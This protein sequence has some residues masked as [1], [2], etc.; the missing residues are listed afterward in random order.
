MGALGLALAGALPLWLGP[1]AEML[2]QG[3]QTLIDA[4]V[5]LSPLTHLAGASGNDLLRNQWLYQHSNLATLPFSYPG[6]AA[7]AGSYAAAIALLALAALVL[8]PAVPSESIP[9]QEK[10]E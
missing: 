6:V 1:A 5:G 4:A 3:R 8:R 9:T 10:P 7:L 2:S